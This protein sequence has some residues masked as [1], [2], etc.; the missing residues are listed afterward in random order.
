MFDALPRDF[1][2]TRYPAVGAFATLAAAA[3]AP[4]A[5]VLRVQVQRYSD[6]SSYAPAWYKRV[7][8]QPSR[9][10]GYENA[11]WFRSVDGGYFE[12]EPDGGTGRVRCAA[13]GDGIAGVRAA[14]SF[15]KRLQ[16]DP[17]FYEMPTTGGTVI[18]A[19]DEDVDIDFS[20][21]LIGQV[22]NCVAFVS[23]A[24][25]Y[26]E[27]FTVTNIASNVLT[28][29]GSGTGALAKGKLIRMGD[30]ITPHWWSQSSTRR[31]VFDGSR[32][33]GE[34]GVVGAVSGNTVTLRQTPEWATDRTPEYAREIMRVD[35]IGVVDNG[36]GACRV[37]LGHKHFGTT[38]INYTGENIG[39][40]PGANGTFPVAVIDDYTVDLVG[41]TFS[42][43]YT[44]GGT[45][46]KS[47]TYSTHATAGMQ[48]GSMR[49]NSCR[50]RVGKIMCPASVT[51]AVGRLIKI[52]ARYVDVGSDYVEKSTGIIF[53][54]IAC[55]GRVEY[56]AASTGAAGKNAGYI[57]T[58]AGSTLDVHVNGSRTTRHT[59][60]GG[61]ASS[62][63]G[64]TGLAACGAAA[65][66]NVYIYGGNFGS[67]E[68][69][70]ATHAGTY[71][72]TF[73]WPKARQTGANVAV[74]GVGH[75]VV[76]ARSIGTGAAGGDNDDVDSGPDGG[77]AF[78]SFCQFAIGV[79]SAEASPV[80]TKIR[81][82][83]DGRAG[84][85][86]E[87]ATGMR[88]AVGGATGA[89][90]ASTNGLRYI[91]VIGQGTIGST[92]VT[93]I[94]LDGTTFS[95]ASGAGDAVVDALLDASDA[96]TIVDAQMEDNPTTMFNGRNN[97]GYTRIEGGTWRGTDT[98]S[99]PYAAGRGLTL[100]NHTTE[101]SG[102]PEDGIVW[103]SAFAE[104]FEA[105]NWKVKGPGALPPLYDLNTRPQAVT[106][107]MHGVHVHNPGGPLAAIYRRNVGTKL[108]PE[109]SRF[110][111]ITVH[112]ECTTLIAGFSME[113]SITEMAAFC[114]GPIIVNK[115][116]LLDAPDA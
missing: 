99:H 48:I 8:A 53:S 42:G 57:L 36:S 107:L 83:V 19:T 39:G 100:I 92:T 105:Y 102:V 11:G 69:A 94:D 81:L 16:G 61:Q 24:G 54:L 13:L 56:Y 59:I 114:D 55:F 25:T 4:L 74:R 72:W 68:A 87:L 95:S 101:F 14:Q 85:G 5:A 96:F 113:D 44:S 60:D 17:I 76:D 12:I 18:T 32:R 15:T 64:T 30:L 29:S 22:Q 104:F 2:Q 112:G 20:D 71:R 86:P 97:G 115:Q 73:Y 98:A 21:S 46:R 103:G 35:V 116:K 65:Y 109:G 31:G 28:L 70:H 82:A 79:V 33:A 51:S 111:N 67:T 106:V 88:V 40:V 90:A 89:S 37:S 80:G 93:Y 9:P 75:T 108:P 58:N 1:L 26:E 3:G 38:G 41:S 34:F 50:V 63:D 7:S 43:S 6:S 45:V 91:T 10:V 23:I 77:G 47:L 62:G 110:G 84:R 27:T 78:S 52:S 49:D 66:T